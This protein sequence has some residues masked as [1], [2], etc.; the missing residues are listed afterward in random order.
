VYYLTFFFIL[1]AIEA[2]FDLVNFTLILQC[3]TPKIIETNIKPDTGTVSYAFV[4]RFV[5]L[6]AGMQEHGAILIYLPIGN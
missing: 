4:Y 3:G 5:H 1:Y 2:I 6:G